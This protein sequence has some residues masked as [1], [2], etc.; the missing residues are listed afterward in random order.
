MLVWQKLAQDLNGEGFMASIPAKLG[1]GGLL[2]ER[3][4][5]IPVVIEPLPDRSGYTAHLAA[6][7]LLSA[8]AASAEEA[9]RQLAV[10]LQRR[11]QQG[12]E[13]RTL[14]VPVAATGGSESGWLPDDELTQDWI[15]LVQQYRAECDAA[16]RER[17]GGAP[18]QEE[19][20][21]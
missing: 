11:L 7:F 2:E 4:M 14:T 15:H 13:L 3:M 5:E 6:P 19:P 12:M 16:D 21:S 9:H 8:S 10:L 18:D 17:L 20:S 1:P